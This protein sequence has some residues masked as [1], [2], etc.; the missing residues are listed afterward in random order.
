MIRFVD[1]YT[2]C[3][4]PGYPCL[5]IPAWSTT[6]TRVSSGDEQA[7][8]RWEHPLHT[9]VLPQAVRSYSNYLAVQKHWYAMRGPLHSWPFRDPLDFASADLSQPNTVPTLSATDQTIGTGDGVTRSF[10]LVKR[11]AVG[12]QYYERKIYLPVLSTVRVA[13]GGVEVTND[14]P[15]PDVN[16]QTGIVTLVTA[17]GVG[18]AVT[19]GFL[20][21]VQVRF[22][23]DESFSGMVKTFNV[24]GYADM[25][26]VE[27]RGPAT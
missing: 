13:V 12:S 18:V 8:Q 1:Q 24:A 11:Y 3:E 5:T 14:S 4:L 25:T 21:D 6:I 16:R 10:Q 27:V 7:N 15:S 22:E 23:S 2:P 9:F 20:F 17:P 19:A 26:L